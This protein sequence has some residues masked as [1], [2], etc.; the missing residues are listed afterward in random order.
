MRRLIEPFSKAMASLRSPEQPITQD[1][2]H[3]SLAAAREL[4]LGSPDDPAIEDDCVAQSR[5]YWDIA[6][7]KVRGNPEQSDGRSEIERIQK[8]GK[9]FWRKRFGAENIYWQFNEM[10]ALTSIGVADVGTKASRLREHVAWMRYMG[11]DNATRLRVIETFDAGPNLYAWQVWVPCS[12]VDGF[13]LPLFVQAEFLAALVRRLLLGLE[14]LNGINLIHNDIKTNNLCLAMPEFDKQKNGVCST[15]IIFQTLELRLI[16][17]ETSFSDQRERFIYPSWQE[18]T[19]PFLKACSEKAMRPNLHQNEKLDI[20]SV[21]DWGSDLW[22]VGFVLDEWI[23]CGQ[24]FLSNWLDAVRDNFGGNSDIYFR[25]D[26]IEDACSKKFKFLTDFVK[27]LKIQDR[28]LSDAGKTRLEQREATHADLRKKLEDKFPVLESNKAIDIY[29]I[30][31]HVPLRASV[32]APICAPFAFYSALIRKYMAQRKASTQYDL[33][34]MYYHGRG[35]PQDD[36]KAVAC[37]QRAADQGHASAQNYLGW[38]YQMGRGVPQDDQCAVDFFRKSADQGNESAQ[39][40]LG[41]MYLLGRGVPQDD[42]SAADWFFKAANQGHAA[43]QFNLGWIY[44]NGRGVPKDDQEAFN[45]YRKAANQGDTSALNYLGGIMYNYGLG[46]LPDHPDAVGQYQ[47]AAAK[48]SSFAQY[49]LG[50]MYK[51]GRGVP[52][53][54][55]RAVNFFRA[56][57]DQGNA[58]AQYDL[59]VMYYHGRGVPQDNQEAAK[60]Y[61]K[62]AD[63][64]KSFAQYDLGLMYQHGL[65][66]PQDYREA[67]EWYRKAAA[68]GNENAKDNLRKLV[69]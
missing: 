6:H 59:A 49:E 45:W 10:A 46:V 18:W 8:N 9:A 41:Q 33:G 47:K 52:Q 5:R 29:W 19:S 40:N 65:G 17:F 66:V 21:I 67:A 51:N 31:P 61:R 1:V 16:D 4:M 35:V 20:L 36:L 68:Q 24:V 26:A 32:R 57:A 54:D 60:W 14:S 27:T 43:G 3:W 53:D 69:E 48:G 39:N 55:L 11:V 37:F 42:W 22:S 15:E 30:D 25:A 7:G 23:R 2:W 44:Q 58:F 62:S 34:V 56:S 50:M 63:Q 13:A 64:G 28:P 38:M 12:K